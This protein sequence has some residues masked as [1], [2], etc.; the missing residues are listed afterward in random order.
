MDRIVEAVY[1][2][3]VL[4]LLEPLELPEHQRVQLTIEGI[5]LPSD[6][7]VLDSEYLRSL[8]QMDIPDV[9]V[10]EVRRALATI[11]GALT[12]DFAAERDERL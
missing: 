4:R 9:S 7:E 10:D 8:E 6:Q 3:G 1:E 5:P 12:P 11:P 2:N